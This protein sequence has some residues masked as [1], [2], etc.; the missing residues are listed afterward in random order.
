MQSLKLRHGVRLNISLMVL[1][2]KLELQRDFQTRVLLVWVATLR[3]QKDFRWS[4]KLR[5][6]RVLVKRLR[7]PMVS[8]TQVL[9][10]Q[11][12]KLRL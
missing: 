12:T 6:Q 10:G 11:V 2:A 3:L 9:L 8:K 1:A 4:P 7:L 5:L